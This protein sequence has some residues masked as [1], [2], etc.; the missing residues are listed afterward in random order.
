MVSPP[1]NPRLIYDFEGLFGLVL[2][3][4]FIEYHQSLLIDPWDFGLSIAD[5]PSTWLYPQML[6]LLAYG[7]LRRTVL[8]FSVKKECLTEIVYEMS[9]DRDNVDTDRQNSSIRFE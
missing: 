7:I 6:H 8:M 1:A 5:S 3:V 2:E 9:S 4:P